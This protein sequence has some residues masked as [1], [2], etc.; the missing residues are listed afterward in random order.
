MDALLRRE[1]TED[2]CG[3]VYVDNKTQPSFI[4]IFDPNNLGTSCSIGLAAPLPAWTLS[5]IP[6]I[7]LPAAFPQTGSRKRWW[8]QLFNS[9][10][11]G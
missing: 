2:Y 10:N 7:D 11:K 9:A 8:Q 1:H 5:K 4:K 6:P 3:V